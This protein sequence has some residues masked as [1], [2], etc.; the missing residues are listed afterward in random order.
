MHI[1]LVLFMFF[2]DHVSQPGCIYGGRRRLELFVAGKKRLFGG[3]VSQIDLH[4]DIG[5][6]AR[7]SKYDIDTHFLH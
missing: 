2:I 5:M 4:F 3:R 1:V 7:G 6:S